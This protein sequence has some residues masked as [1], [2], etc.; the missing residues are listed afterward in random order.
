MTR[1]AGSALGRRFF[2]QAPIGAYDSGSDFRNDNGTGQR[3]SINKNNPGM[4][5]KEPVAM[6][7]KRRDTEKKVRRPDKPRRW[8][9][10]A[11]ASVKWWR[12]S[13]GGK[14]L[15]LLGGGTLGQ[16]RTEAR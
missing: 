8:Q 2:D 1:A 16:R 13:M 9:K 14:I 10:P 6:R 7:M 15:L 11:A 4:A 12:N 3:K 5:L